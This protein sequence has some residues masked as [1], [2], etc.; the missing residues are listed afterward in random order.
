[1]Q[2]AGFDV[3]VGSFEKQGIVYHAAITTPKNKGGYSRAEEYKV[4]LSHP[5]K[6]TVSFKLKQDEQ[7]RW[8]PDK[9]R[10][11]DPWIADEIGA[12]IESKILKKEG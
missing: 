12:I 8:M 9:R 10:Q 11:V 5:N 4:L 7:A 2:K 6:R 1:M 3:V